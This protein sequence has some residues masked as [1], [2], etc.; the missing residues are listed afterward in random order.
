MTK[1]PDGTYLTPVQIV[2]V[3]LDE[4]DGFDRS[5]LR[6]E[7]LTAEDMVQFHLTAGMGIRNRFGL[8]DKENPHTVNDA[9]PNEQGIVDHPRHPDNL[10]G[11]ILEALW[12]CVVTG[13]SPE[14]ACQA[15]D[16][17]Q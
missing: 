7:V 4:L 12:M 9:E 3:L 11:A 10:S 2:R 14:V 5:R 1:N 15:K 8:W 17:D 16:I 13:V 6:R